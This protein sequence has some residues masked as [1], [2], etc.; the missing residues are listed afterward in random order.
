MDTRLQVLKISYQ[1]SLEALK[2]ALAVSY[3]NKGVENV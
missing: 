3:K 1:S 2:K